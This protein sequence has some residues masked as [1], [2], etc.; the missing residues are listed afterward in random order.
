MSESFFY[1]NISFFIVPIFILAP[2]INLSFYFIV[3][4]IVSFLL[5][6]KPI[7][8]YVISTYTI[9]IVSFISFSVDNYS[10]IVA[11]KELFSK[12]IVEDFGL[13]DYKGEFFIVAWA[14]ILHSLGFSSEQAYFSLVMLSFF[15]LM[16]ICYSLGK[17]W[18]LVIFLLVIFGDVIRMTPFALRQN[19]ATLFVLWFFMK[20]R[21]IYYLIPSLTIHLTS[22]FYVT[23]LPALTTRFVYRNYFLILLVMFVSYS[24]LRLENIIYVGELLKSFYG[25][26]W[27]LEYY[28][29]MSREKTEL[30]I[31]LTNKIVA[32]MN[33]SLLF[34]L[35]RKH[36]IL[37]INVKIVMLFLL[38][39]TLFF[40]TSNIPALPTRVGYLYLM[41]MP[42]L[43]PIYLKVVLSKHVHII[44]KMISIVLISFF[45]IKAFSFIIKNELSL[46]TF[47]IANNNLLSSSIQQL[48]GFL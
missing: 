25:T 36:D 40:L 26:A 39:A 38:S 44:I 35:V 6:K 34:Y 3:A 12:F 33:I 8:N 22:F 27:K 19:L 45:V 4:L 14:K 41:Y 13:F 17:R 46:L 29:S 20:S 10:D 7:I 32:L 1:K 42:L 37:M 23:I 9:V 43:T 2:F 15:L 21:K 31:S 5:Y 11:Y 28:I 30:Y 16:N 48:M 47:G 18:F 24:L